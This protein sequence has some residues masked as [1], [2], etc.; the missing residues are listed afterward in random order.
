M[1]SDWA[2]FFALLLLAA[3]LTLALWLLS[4]PPP[5]QEQALI[6]GL[7]LS[8]EQHQLCI[9]TQFRG[10]RKSWSASQ[11]GRPHLFRRR[12]IMHITG[13]DEF[14]MYFHDQYSPTLV[15][16]MLAASCKAM[17]PYGLLCGCGLSVFWVITG[18]S[19]QLPFSFGV[20]YA[21]TSSLITPLLALAY[22]VWPKEF[23]VDDMMTFISVKSRR[24]AQLEL[25]NVRVRA[26]KCPTVLLSSNEGLGS[27]LVDLAPGTHVTHPFPAP[28]ARQVADA[29]NDR[30]FKVGGRLFT[31]T[32]AMVQGEEVFHLKHHVRSIRW[33]MLLP[34]EYLTDR[35]KGTTAFL[36]RGDLIKIALLLDLQCEALFAAEALALSPVLDLEDAGLLAKVVN[37]T[38]PD[39]ACPLAPLFLRVPRRM[40][41]AMALHK[42][43]P[44]PKLASRLHPAETYLQEQALP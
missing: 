28:T 1:F 21:L 44:H 27:C 41:L 36:S 18:G 24:E 16:L 10:S 26:L 23:I 32:E 20:N 9:M 2:P 22:D 15:F 43:T 31:V 42:S 4:P 39:G 5:P 14:R 6:D 34:E 13:I 25:D 37:Q 12:R 38:A 40:A 3:C 33:W 19:F 8:R 29:L 17:L 30:S 7:T 35:K 11:L